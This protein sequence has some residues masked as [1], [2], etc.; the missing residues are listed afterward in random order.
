MYDEISNAYIFVTKNAI[1]YRIYFLKDETL[2]SISGEDI[3]NVYQ[4]IIEKNNDEVEPY[5][6]KVSKTIEF[7][8]VEFFKT[9]QNSIIYIC[10]DTDDRAKQRHLTFSRWYQKSFYKEYIIKLDNI[11]TIGEENIYTSLMFHKENILS[12]KLI[13]IYQQIEKVLQ[14]DK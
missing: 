10:S 6:I 2:A 9:I 7:I 12:S 13:Q 5:D 11:I 3:Q 14:E 4:I 1:L 8:V